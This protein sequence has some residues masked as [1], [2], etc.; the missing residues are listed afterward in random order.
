V[1]ETQTIVNASTLAFQNASGTLKT[2]LDAWLGKLDTFIE[3]VDTYVTE[4]C[5]SVTK[6]HTDL[7]NGLPADIQAQ[8]SAMT[9]SPY[10]QY[11]NFL[12]V[13]F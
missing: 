2:S 6:F 3:D 8:L 9:G 4:F 5:P 10:L 13:L 11:H 7:N 12:S 1:G